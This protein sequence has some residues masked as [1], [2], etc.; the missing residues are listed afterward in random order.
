[1]VNTRNRFILTERFI[2]LFKNKLLSL[3]VITVLL[4]TTGTI[5][6]TGTNNSTP[7]SINI[8]NK[9]DKEA[10]FQQ[11]KRG[12]KTWQT[13]ATIKQNATQS[14]EISNDNRKYRLQCGNKISRSITGKK[15]VSKKRMAAWIIEGVDNNY[16]FNKMRVRSRTGATGSTTGAT[17]DTDSIIIDDAED[18][19]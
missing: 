6:T 16:E 3:M 8:I 18:A 19:D 12:H 7:Y 1:M 5:T 14:V 2:M 11:R 17:D 15:V 10:I 4:G 9:T 13:I